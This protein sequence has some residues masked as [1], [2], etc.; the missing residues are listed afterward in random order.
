[1]PFWMQVIVQ[2]ARSESLGCAFIFCG[3]LV[4]LSVLLSR[5][6]CPASRRSSAPVAKSAS[7]TGRGARCGTAAT[8]RR[9][10]PRRARAPPRPSARGRPTTAPHRA[11]APTSSWPRRRPRPQH[12]ARRRPRRSR[13]RARAAG[14]RKRQG[15][16]GAY[17][18]RCIA[19]AL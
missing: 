9:R 5:I 11:S 19:K 3:T 8:P 16:N 12:R 10:C 15:S 1:M 17:K 14:E 4:A 13:R 7:D 18:P 2:S 6:P